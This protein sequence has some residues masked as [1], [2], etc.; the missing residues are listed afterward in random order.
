MKYMPKCYQYGKQSICDA[1][2]KAILDVLVSDNLTGGPATQAFEKA[3]CDYTGAQYCV[4]T[5]SATAA[6]HMLMTC[7][8]IEQGDEVITSPNTFVASANCIIYAGG[9]PVFAD[10]ETD[11]A[12][13]DVAE[14]KKHITS[15]TKALLPV[16]FAGQSCDMEPIHALAKQHGLYVIEDAAHAIGSDYK[17]KKVGACAFSDA[18]VFSFH[19]VK[20]ITAGEGGAI[21]TNNYTLYKKLLATRSHGIYKEGEMLESWHYEMRHIGYNYRMSDIQAALG[22]SQ[23]GKL[24]MFKR[25]RREIVDYY[26]RH[27]QLPHLVERHYSH[28]CFHLYPVLVENRKQFYEKAKQAGL[29][30]QIHYIPVHTQPYYQRLGYKWGD[31]PRSER[32]YHHCVSLPL[33]PSLTDEDLE[34]IVSR[35]KA[36]F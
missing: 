4:V 16:H 28:A 18:T 6:L 31:Y 12:N 15:R 8:G 22:L 33:Y 35:L 11:T 25:R 34:E 7:I 36:I 14:I 2:K 13:I 3:I 30:L 10:I 20:T 29:F 27:L 26:N 24:E 32:Y 5:S 9:K 19:P 17:G 21:T 1:D 23:L